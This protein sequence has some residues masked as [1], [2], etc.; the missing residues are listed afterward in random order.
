M[1]TINKIIDGKMYAEKLLGEIHPLSKGFLDNFDRKPCLTVILVGDNPASK[2]YVKNKILIAKKIGIESNEILLGSDVT[3]DELIHHISILNKDENV[4][5]I[6][7]Q[8]PLPKHISEKKIINIICPSKDV[9]GFHPK[10]FGKLFMGDPKFIPCTPLGCL[11]MLKHEIEDI[12]GKNAVI[13]GR[14]NIVGKP[15]ASLLLSSDCSVT[16]THSKTKNI[17]KHARK[18][19]ILIIAVGIPEMIDEKFI[20]PGAVVIDVGINRSVSKTNDNSGNKGKLVG[21]VKFENVLK[22]AKKIT[23]VPGGVGPMTIAC[24]MHNTVKAAYINKKNDFINVLE[25]IL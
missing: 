16:I 5:G 4:D 13:I 23:P 7:V 20:K 25:G 2:I 19:D 21:D 15:M 8:L 17:E 22:I 10:N 11:Y 18:A 12:K 1:T 14:S 9:D 6:L 3:E 24:L